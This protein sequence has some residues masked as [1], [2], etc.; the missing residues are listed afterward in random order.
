MS[1]AEESCALCGDRHKDP[2]SALVHM[3]VA[4][5][6]LVG[7]S[8]RKRKRVRA[9]LPKFGNSLERAGFCEVDAHIAMR[10]LAEELRNAGLV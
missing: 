5:G 9:L 4:H 10:I 2:G 7:A 1:N 6:P 8:S 3:L